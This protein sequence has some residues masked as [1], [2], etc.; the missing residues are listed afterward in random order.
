MQESQYRHLKYASF[1][2]GGQDADDRDILHWL[3]LE[4]WNYCDEPDAI[5]LALG[6]ED[7][8]LE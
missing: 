4:E 7:I 5:M 2:D 8:H 6:R 3:N 1:F